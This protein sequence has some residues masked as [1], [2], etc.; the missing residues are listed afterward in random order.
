MSQRTANAAAELPDEWDRLA[1]ENPYLKKN[2]LRF[3]ERTERDFRPTYYMFYDN[4]RLDSC[5]VAFKMRR[6]NLGMF[7]RF[8]FF[9]PVTMIYLPM[10][11]SRPGMVIG[12]LKGEVLEAIRGIKGFTLA[13]N[14]EDGDAEGFATGLTCPKCILDVRWKSFDE[15]VASLRSDYRSRMKKILK[16]S[17][18]LRLRFIDGATEFGEE[19]Y[20]LYR[21]V[22]DRSDA[23]IE[24]LSREYFT[25]GNFKIFVAE[26][27]GKTVGFTQLL[28][29]GS[30]LI[31]E[32]VGLDYS[33]NREYKVYHRMLAEIIRYAV[34]HGFETVDF[35]QTAD[36][37]KLKL[38]A[39][40]T[41]LYAWLRHSCPL[42]NFFCKRLK[43][44]L[45]YK[46]LETRYRVF[47]GEQA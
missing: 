41:Y 29:N 1:G 34:E 25:G 19:A 42:I 5:F 21:N 44:K 4:A 3:I 35:G 38:G 13:L 18:A 20:R 16:R 22:L 32:F 47:K 17:E 9:A 27:D 37:A 46:P 12:R 24:T 33:C 26:L 28:E 7:A 39:R 43:N 31:F 30:E 45:V 15:Y 6:F 40:Y 11:V 8:D 2:F 10:S 23:K 36:D 14:L